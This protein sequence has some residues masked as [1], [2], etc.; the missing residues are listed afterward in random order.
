MPDE[1]LPIRSLAMTIILALLLMAVS[2][3]MRIPRMAW[4][5]G[6]GASLSVFSLGTLIYVVPRLFVPGK[7]SARFWMA[8][9]AFLKLPIFMIVLYY[10]IRLES[11]KYID[12]VGVF[13]GV[14]LGPLTILLKVLGWQLVQNPD[15]T[16]RR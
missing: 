16:D 8:F 12:P 9:V 4:G 6:I 2:F 3:L 1:K 11:H 10:A 13:S 5:I 15:Q 14:A 7:S